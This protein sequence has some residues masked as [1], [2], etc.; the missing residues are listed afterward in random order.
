MKTFIG[1]C[2]EYWIGLTLFSILLSI[3]YLFIYHTEEASYKG[4][5]LEHYVTF[6]KYGDPKYFTIAS[7]DDGYIRTLQGLD[8]YVRPIGSS[9]NYTIRVIK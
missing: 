1:F 2:K 9:V 5:V 3:I 8:Y 6:N 7:F 4:T